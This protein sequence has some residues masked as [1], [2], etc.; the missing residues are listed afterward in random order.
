MK[1]L[2]YVIISS[3]L[4]LFGWCEDDECKETSLDEYFDVHVYFQVNAD[5]FYIEHYEGI[6]V[7][8]MMEKY[9]CGGSKSG[10]FTYTYEIAES[11]MGVKSGIGTYSFTMQNEKDHL[12]IR[13]ESRYDA[14]ETITIFPDEILR[15]GRFVSTNRYNILI[16]VYLYDYDDRWIQ[17][18]MDVEF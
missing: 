15:K 3:L 8:C 10:P 12:I 11:G 1:A 17:T 5:L 13:V 9:H 4:F 7:N 6:M 16:K 14:D 18:E 2:T